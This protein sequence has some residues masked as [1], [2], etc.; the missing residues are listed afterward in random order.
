MGQSTTRRPAVAGRFYPDHPVE[1]RETVEKCI[2]VAG[3]DAA[4]ERVAA[5]VAPHAGYVYSG[6]TAGY[7][8]ARVRGKKPNRVILLGCSHRFALDTA[9]VFTRGAFET[10]LGTF[11]IDE[12]FADKVAEETGAET[13]E[14]HLMEHALEVQLPF[15]YVALGEVPIVPVLFGSPPARWHAQMGEKIAGLAEEDDLL[16]ASTDLSHYL[17]EHEA[18]R[19]DKQSLDTLLSKDWN[20]YSVGIATGACAMCGSPAITAA[21]TYSLAQGADEWILLDYRTSADASGDH[22][23]VVGYAAV[24]MERAG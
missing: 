18:H 2:G 12:D 11:P 9:S 7:A 15:L 1:L 8:Y 10:P 24:S 17:S 5:I 3:V 20:A 22:D 4:P 19:R 13:T 16:V 21:M 6:A 23:R 14:P